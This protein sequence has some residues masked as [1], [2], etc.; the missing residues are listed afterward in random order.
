[1]SSVAA[2]HQRLNLSLLANAEKRL[3]I[4][5]ARRLPL[6]VHSDHLSLLAF[7]SML[8]ASAGFVLM[9]LTPWG[10]ALVAAGLVC[11]WFGD[12]LDG[13]VA[14][15]RGHERPRFGYYVDHAI[16]LAGTTALFVGLAGSGLM[17]PLLAVAVLAAYLL[18]SAETYLATHAGGTFRMSWLGFGPTELR[19]LIV[20]GT[21]YAAAD[22]VVRIPGF[23]THPLF[24]AGG[25]VA[26]PALLL[27]FLSSSAKQTRALYLQE[28]RP[29][30]SATTVRKSL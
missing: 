9:R 29:T 27:A 17:T 13:T 18:V 24:D 11:N 16:D 26:L 14:R 6:A 20:V 25:A 23:G 2:S 22:P 5:L 15:V 10:S 4:G 7:A 12:S 3:L 8:V 30:T 28:P 21:L 1:M 19:V